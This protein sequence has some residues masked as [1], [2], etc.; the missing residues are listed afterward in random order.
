MIDLNGQTRKQNAVVDLIDKALVAKNKKAAPRNYLGASLLGEECLRKLQFHFFHVPPDE[1][2]GFNGRILRIFE[3]GHAAEGRMIGYLKMAGF[4]LRTT[5]KNGRQ[6]E[7]SLLD[8]MIKGHCD[9]VLVAG[10]QMMQY[11][12]L[13]ENKCLGAKYWKQLEKERLKKF[14]PVYYGQVQIMQAYFELTDSPALFTA[15]NADTEEI[16][17]ELIPF[18]AETAQKVSDNAVT[19]IKA[20]EAG[21]ILPRLT[22]DP[23]FFKCRW[24]DWHD[25]CFAL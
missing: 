19:V 24:C 4:D 10:P 15:L 1:G 2:K 22:D 23:T 16:Y 13:W 14:S 12:A 25:R 5:G 7:F 18:D 20:C 8:G 17:V 9:G 3:R 11:P 6:F 21:E